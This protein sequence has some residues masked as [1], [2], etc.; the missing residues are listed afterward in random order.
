MKKSLIF[1]ST[2]I[3]AIIIFLINCKSNSIEETLK[4]SSNC[5]ISKSV[6]E[7][8]NPNNS[9]KQIET[10]D[11]Q[12]DTQGNLTKR[13]L[14][15]DRAIK[16]ET[17]E[18]QTFTYNSNGFLIEKSTKTTNTE[19][20]TATIQTT[21]WLE[22]YTYSNDRLATAEISYTNRKGV[23]S[24]ENIKYLYNMDSVLSSRENSKP[25]GTIATSSYDN[26]GL[27]TDYVV[28]SS[29]GTTQPY[30]IQNGLVT[31]IKEKLAN[32]NFVY[33]ENR[34][35]TKNEI[36]IDGKLNSYINFEYN[37]ALRA[38]LSLPKFK[39]FPIIKN[40]MGEEGVADKFQYFADTAGDGKMQQGNESTF[41]NQ[42][43]S[44]GLITK[45]DLTNKVLPCSFSQ[46]NIVPGYI[47]KSTQVFT[48]T[49]CN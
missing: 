42:K 8:Q 33:D 41:V 38:E 17:Q 20:G 34:H 1:R 12:Y 35:I 7:I 32:S 10:I 9:Y 47:T 4:P 25:D 23:T 28:K 14:V 49:D 44:Y 29:T 40:E 36:Y 3:I 24:V 46:G 26:K 11:Y 18:I 27:L 19:P 5:R 16:A 6:N 48:Y 22:K 43:N 13:S 21:S 31:K 45:I 15:I 30:T 2:I 39:G 37:N